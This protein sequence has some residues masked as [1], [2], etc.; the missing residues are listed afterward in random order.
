ME[1]I[2]AYFYEKTGMYIDWDQLENI[3]EVDTLIDIGVGRNGTEILYK[4]F[5][6]SKLILIDPLIEAKNYANQ[7]LKHRDY[8]FFQ[9]AVGE[10]NCKS[11]INVEKNIGRSSLLNVT[12]INY[13][14]KPIE[15]R[16]I[17]IKTV[18]TILND[19]LRELG[20]IGIKI[21]TEGY[22]LNVAKGAIKTLKKTKFLIAEVR[23]NYQS[24]E[25]QYKLHQFIDFMNENDF[26][27]S[28]ILTAKPL[29]ADLCFQP[30]KDLIK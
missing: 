4:R 15:E 6:S 25:G 24:F 2:K 9:Y 14:G 20:S 3:P 19:S 22:E 1:K 18:D 10:E 30:K 7:N 21:D 5:N 8:K 13:E 11:K 29:I 23:H 28:R 16:V 27:L 17:E 12:E 26:L